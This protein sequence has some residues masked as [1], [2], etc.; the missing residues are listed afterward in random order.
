LPEACQWVV[1]GGPALVHPQTGIGF[2]WAGGTHTYG[3][4]MPDADRGQALAAGAQ[5]IF[6]Y[7]TGDWL[8]LA[9]IGEEWVLAKWL[10][11]EPQWCLRAYENAR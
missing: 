10:D 5:T 3:L 2:G 9:R 11:A 4:R 6:K 7:S 8:D 1:Y